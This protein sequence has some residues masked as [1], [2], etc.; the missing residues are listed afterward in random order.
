M[1]RRVRPKLAATLGKLKDLLW[2]HHPRPAL[3]EGEE[4]IREGVGIFLKGLHGWRGGHLI[5][6]NRRLIWYEPSVARPLKPISGQ[7]SLSDIASADTG[8]LF[9]LVFGGAPLRL[10]LRDGRDKCIWE[11]NGRLNEWVAMIR[12][13]IAGEEA[14]ERRIRQRALRVFLRIFAW[15]ISGA[16]AF[17]ILFREPLAAPIGFVL[18]A[19]GGILSY[20]PVWPAALVLMALA[21]SALGIYFV[22]S[23][24]A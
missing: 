6:T 19:I 13:V 1:T 22:V 7:L 23:A 11:G 3:E 9:D 14:R 8:T 2:V 17:L 15:A 5:L 16:V 24:I 4:L 10:R 21:G 12:G 20:L 18:G